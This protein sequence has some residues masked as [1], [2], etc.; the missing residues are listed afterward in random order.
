M[1]KLGYLCISVY[2]SHE[3]IVYISFNIARVM[4]V[5]N[6]FTDGRINIDVK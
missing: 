5:E 6:M 1:L 4:D 2:N 3:K